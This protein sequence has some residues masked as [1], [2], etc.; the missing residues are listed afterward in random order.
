MNV[1]DGFAFSEKPLVTVQ[2]PQQ[3]L[4]P[5]KW[6]SLSCFLFSLV[7][8]KG[9]LRRVT[10]VRSQL[11]SGLLKKGLFGILPT[12]PL[13]FLL[14]DPGSGLGNKGSAHL[15]DEPLLDLLCGGGIKGGGVPVPLHP[16]PGL[17][18]FFFL[19]SIYYSIVIKV[20]VS[21]TYCLDLNPGS[22]MC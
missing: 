2:H 3:D 11:G 21:G 8:E 9:Q 1:W 14:T 22:A 17:G 19:C 18:T 16:T 12:V 6:A 5:R 15:S 13:S 4:N 10:G 7:C 20:M